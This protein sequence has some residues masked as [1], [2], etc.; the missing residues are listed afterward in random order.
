MVKS[1][2]YCGNC[3]AGQKNL[4]SGELECWLKPAQPYAIVQ[5]APSQ[6]DPSQVKL[7]VKV[8]AI[9]PPVQETEFCLDGQPRVHSELVK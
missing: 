8:I 7:G 4:R 3:I 1:I 6:L 9:R 5:S 2:V